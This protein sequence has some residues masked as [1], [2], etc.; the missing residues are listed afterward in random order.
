MPI[1]FDRLNTAVTR[2]F[3]TEA[4]SQH[5]TYSSKNGGE[6]FGVN[7]IFDRYVSVTKPSDD[8]VP[9]TVR[10]STLSVLTCDMP[11]GWQHQQGDRVR[12]RGVK[13]D[14]GELGHS[15]VFDVAEVQPDGQGMTVLMLTLAYDHA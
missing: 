14:G 12:I 7:G 9:V 3:G 13:I 2:R 1:G 8:G 10:Y 11:L 4:N 15:I 5:A 6:P